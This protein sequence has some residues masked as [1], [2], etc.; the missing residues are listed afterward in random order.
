MAIFIA[1][2][3]AFIILLMLIGPENR[4]KNLDIIES[5]NDEKTMADDDSLEL[6]QTHT[7]KG[8][9]SQIE[10]VPQRY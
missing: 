2:V 5:A 9:V 8:D 6:N 3:Y 1:C 10:V 4:G 7:G